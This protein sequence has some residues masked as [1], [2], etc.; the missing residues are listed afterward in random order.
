MAAPDPGRRGRRIAVVSL[1]AHRALAPRGERTRHLVARLR[2]DW[3]V[4]LVAPPAAMATGG[5]AGSGRSSLPRRAAARA[6][7]ATLLDKWEPWS[8]RN[9][10]RWQSRVDA[11]LLIGHPFSPLVYA[12]RRLRAAGIP[13]AV[14]VGDPWV[15]TTAGHGMRGVAL[16]RAR[17]AERRLWQG[18]AAAVLTTAG[19]AAGVSEVSPEL[20]TLV[21]P[22]GYDGS[23]PPGEWAI[24]P[25]TAGSPLRIAH[26]GMFNNQ[27]LD[28]RP[29][30]ARLAGS[31]LWSRVS[32]AQFGDDFAGFLD[33]PPAGVEVE[34]HPAYPWQQVL[35]RAT[36]F[37]LAVVVG[38]VNPS[39]L[40]SKA[41]QYLTL[42]IPRLAI[43]RGDDSLAAYLA[44]KPGWL[45]LGAERE[46]APAAVRAHLDRNWS[47]AQLDA[48]RSESWPAVAD[49]IADFL[50]RRLGAERAGAR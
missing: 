41:V 21:R 2:R 34:R 45:V 23:S 36:D 32:L 10:G 22:N 25:V 19:Q 16:W 30:L 29:L 11:A 15:L 31:G 24:A 17:R 9:L 4:E 35:N 12:A 28:P 40:P 3:E 50:E 6:V 43:S 48:P 18:A 49:A 44:D 38:N 46:D 39:Q 1:H 27:R 47:A 42:P 20:A 8:A 7:A 5:A 13:Y 26:F 14:D 37:D 33:R